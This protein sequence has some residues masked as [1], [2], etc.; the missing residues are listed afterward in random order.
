MEFFNLLESFHELM[1][2]NG[3]WV[4]GLLNSLLH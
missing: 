3:S 2:I 4:I 1:T